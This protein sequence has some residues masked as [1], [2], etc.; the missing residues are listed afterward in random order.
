MSL[1]AVVRHMSRSTANPAGRPRHA[2]TIEII[3]RDTGPR[4]IQGRS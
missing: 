3:G 4:R 1:P 2:G